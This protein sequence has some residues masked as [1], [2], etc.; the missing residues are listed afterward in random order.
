[1]D[2]PRSLLPYIVR[3]VAVTLVYV[4]GAKLG[5]AVA[6]IH[7]TVSPVW[8]PTGLAIAALTLW[9]PRYW[10]AVAVG[11]FLANLSI[12]DPAAVAAGIALGNTLE[13]L[14]GAM[15]LR[16][17]GVRSELRHV[18]DAVAVLAVAGL[19][20]LPSATIGI[21]S[22]SAGGLLAG[23]QTQQ[24]WLVW[25]IGDSMGALLLVPVL[26][27][28]GGKAA[29]AA[30]IRWAELA[31]ILVVVTLATN[32]AYLNDRTLAELPMPRIPISL[33][34]LP[35]LVWSAL[36]LPPRGA[37]LAL[38]VMGA[39]AV[40]HTVQE[41]GPMAERGLIASLSWLQLMLVGI[42][43]TSLVLIGAIAERARITA[44]L[45]AAK[46]RADEANQAK[47]RFVAAI[48]HDISQ[49]LQA[50]Q[51]F[52][53]VLEGQ[54]LSARGRSVIE[55]AKGSLEAMAAALDALKDITSVEIDLVHPQVSVF[56]ASTLLNQLAEESILQAKQ[57][58][59]EFRYVPCSCL[60]QTDPQILGRL[61]R[62][63]LSNAF[64]YTQHGRVLLGCRRHRHSVSIEVWDTGPGIPRSEQDAIFKTF[65][66]GAGPGGP[67]DNEGLGLGLATVR[68]LASLLS[69]AI[70][71]RSEVGQGSMF[72]VEVPAPD[73]RAQRS[74][75]PS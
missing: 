71:V 9:G 75:G 69:L 8:P 2:R 33:F 43:G 56:P 65:Y 66:R 16:R 11:A 61:L 52:L 23:V 42:G 68:R 70:A 51:L 26:L 67:A 13:A 14:L 21:L 6:F 44:E 72:S 49:P 74:S 38:A 5:L 12:P 39:C 28:W 17:L 15:A 29:D 54:S 30:S 10:P 37:T 53:A 50:V 62:N 48:R 47:T 40:W 7:G 57:R 3:L 58:G 22:L 46:W 27:G 45:A 60:V 19:A 24:A 1:M 32:A 36:R 55:H 31:A 41:R 4:G 35:P 63:L 25:W 73:R 18:S 64:R 34:L 20:P 59:L